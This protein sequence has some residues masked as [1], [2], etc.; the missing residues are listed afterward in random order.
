MH[1]SQIRERGRF[2]KLNNIV[3]QFGWH[4]SI[5]KCKERRKRLT[6]ARVT[7]MDIDEEKVIELK[8][9]ALPT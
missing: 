3:F 9:V 4:K 7:M 8:I 1:S 6:I 2:A 5:E